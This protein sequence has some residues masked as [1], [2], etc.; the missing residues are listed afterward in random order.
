MK[1]IF[2][3]FLFLLFLN[4]TAYSQEA[5]NQ[6]DANGKMHGVWKKTYPESNQ[7]RYEG[8]FNHGKEV[9]TFKYYCETCGNQP[10]AI[11]VFS[12]KDNSVWVQYFTIEGK[13][14]SEG[15]M[16]AKER[17]GEWVSYHEKSKLV[18]SREVYKKGKLNGKQTTYYANGKTTEEITYLDG[19]KEG[20]NLY[21]SPEGVIIKKLLYRNDLLEGPATY[22]DAFG[23]V[24]IE[25]N[26]KQGKK[27]G[28]WRYFKNGKLELE[29]TYPKP[30]KKSN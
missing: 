28:L 8:T 11:S 21:Y 30:L 15:K 2:V 5:I 24:V 19:I 23:V 12:D 6:L 17:E 7:L 14:V 1:Y 22:Y 27:H 3:S 26:Y 20:E 9:G 10:T 13:L 29:E 25:G 18:M 16:I 4:V